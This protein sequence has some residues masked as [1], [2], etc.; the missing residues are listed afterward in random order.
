MVDH[1]H[2]CA[3]ILVSNCIILWQPKVRIRGIHHQPQFW[4]NPAP[5]VQD[6]KPQKC[7]WQNQIQVQRLRQIILTANHDYP[8][9]TA[10]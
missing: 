6:L 2:K 5:P 4:I 8:C 10:V 3:A 9:R 1:G 7:A